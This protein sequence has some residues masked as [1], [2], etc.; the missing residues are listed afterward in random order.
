MLVA[1][2]GKGSLSVILNEVKNLVLW[3]FSKGFKSEILR[4]YAPQ[5]DRGRGMP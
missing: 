3:V 4:R 5:D 2:K 1:G